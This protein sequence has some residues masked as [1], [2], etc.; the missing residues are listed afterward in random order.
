MYQKNSNQ[1]NQWALKVHSS[2]QIQA[3]EKAILSFII[4]FGFVSYEMRER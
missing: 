1:S 4:C 2:K 3:Q